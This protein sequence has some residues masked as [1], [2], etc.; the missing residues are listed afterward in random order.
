V[1]R[2]RAGKPPEKRPPR[3]C[4]RTDLEHDSLQ[5]KNVEPG[6][7]VL[8]QQHA[9]GLVAGPSQPVFLGQGAD[10]STGVRRGDM[11]LRHARQRGVEKK[12]DPRRCA[13][14]LVMVVDESCRRG[15][16]FVPNE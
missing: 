3:R 12:V 14:H 8:A 13:R 7:P 15:G 16:E 9:D 5:R 11:S 6:P 10:A 4:D 1:Q 2:G